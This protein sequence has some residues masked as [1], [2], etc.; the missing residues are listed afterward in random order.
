MG[1]LRCLFETYSGRLAG[2]S[3]WFAYGGRHYNRT[4]SSDEGL[5]H[6][7]RMTRWRVILMQTAVALYRTILS[8]LMAPFSIM[9]A[10]L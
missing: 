4:I 3:N 9:T 10:K 2:A 7:Y 1:R 8:D 5:K 6:V